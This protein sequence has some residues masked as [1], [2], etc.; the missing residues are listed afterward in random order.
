MT[1]LHSLYLE[2][3][4][5][6]GVILTAVTIPWVLMTKKESTSAVAWCLLVFFVPILGSL[7]RQMKPGTLY[8]CR[9]CPAVLLTAAPPPSTNAVDPSIQRPG[10]PTP[11]DTDISRPARPQEPA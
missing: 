4:A 7:R 3:T 9:H 10:T 11:R 2:I 5:I 8:H 1:W 6:L